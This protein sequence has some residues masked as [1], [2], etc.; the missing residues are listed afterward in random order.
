MLCA[1]NNKKIQV[2]RCIYHNSELFHQCSKYF[3]GFFVAALSWAPFAN[4]KSVWSK[5]CWCFDLGAELLMC[6]WFYHLLLICPGL[7]FYLQSLW[8]QKVRLLFCVPVITL[9]RNPNCNFIEPNHLRSQAPSLS[10]LQRA[11]RGRISVLLNKGCCRSG[12][13]CSQE[14][15]HRQNPGNHRSQR[16]RVNRWGWEVGSSREGG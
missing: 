6:S 15:L 3:F 8:L 14:P 10:I 9:T 12:A 1:K 11:G 13:S 5:K 4:T 2:E 16:E 7:Y